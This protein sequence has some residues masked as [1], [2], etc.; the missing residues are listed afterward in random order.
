MS[1]YW[2]NTNL[3]FFTLR[4]LNYWVFLFLV[5]PLTKN[6]TCHDENSSC[7]HSIMVQSHP[8]QHSE[9]CEKLDGGAMVTILILKILWSTTVLSLLSAVVSVVIT[10]V[11]L[12]LRCVI[13]FH[14]HW[15]YDKELDSNAILWNRQIP[16]LVRNSAH[17][18]CGI[19]LHPSTAC[20]TDIIKRHRHDLHS[21]PGAI[22]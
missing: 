3:V 6:M 12:Q 8:K 17:M 16:V 21:K 1:A 15:T 9:K 22:W 19:M 18:R 20:C 7:L 14:N 13:H 5:D 10:H 2:P 11:T 4:F